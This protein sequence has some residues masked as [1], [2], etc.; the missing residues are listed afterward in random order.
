MDNNYLTDWE[1]KMK[2]TIDNRIN[3]EVNSHLEKEKKST[4]KTY[5][6]N[7]LTEQ[8]YRREKEKEYELVYRYNHTLDLLVNCGIDIETFKESYMYKS[9]RFY[10]L[11]RCIQDKIDGYNYDSDGNRISNK[12]IMDIDNTKCVYERGVLTIND[13]K[14]KYEFTMDN[15]Q[16]IYVNGK[17]VLKLQ[18]ATHDEELEEKESIQKSLGKR[19][20]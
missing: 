17:N 4:K 11:L 2:E 19:K 7:P 18:P 3:E 20:K 16:I 1:I 8:L 10:I 12:H 9:H 13:G 15:Q 6:S 5:W 14:V